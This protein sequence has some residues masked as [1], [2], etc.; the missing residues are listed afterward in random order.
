MV[1]LGRSCRP[2]S[3]QASLHTAI[4]EVA[5]ACERAE[6]TLD[7]SLRAPH[8]VHQH[9]GQRDEVQVHADRRLDVQVHTGAAALA[10]LRQVQL[11]AQVERE[12]TRS[13]WD[14]KT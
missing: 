1:V 13:V 3:S 4:Q 7:G 8:V 9:H 11:I 6:V 5:V 2:S 10:H 12:E 14:S